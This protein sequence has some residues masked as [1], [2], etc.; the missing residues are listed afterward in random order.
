M[1]ECLILGDSIAVG[2]AQQRPE[3]V[4]YA[5]V[6]INSYTWNN[7]NITKTLSAKT[8]IISLGANDSSKIN[9]RGELLALRE[10]TKADLVF[11][12]LPNNKPKV[13]PFIRELAAH[14]G[15]VVLPIAVLSSD[16]IHPTAK[17]YKILANQTR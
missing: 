11:W 15:D 5:K 2:V 13:H 8:V 14:Y 4:V 17:G 1:L 9:T 7:K 3:C 10:L 12:I 6:G 16:N